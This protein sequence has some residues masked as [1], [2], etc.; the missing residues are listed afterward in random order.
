MRKLS[1]NSNLNSNVKVDVGGDI[2]EL[3]GESIKWRDVFLLLKAEVDKG[4]L[5]AESVRARSH[6]IIGAFGVLNSSFSA[7]N[8][9][10]TLFFDNS[11]ILLK[12]PFS[13]RPL[14]RAK[15]FLK[16]RNVSFTGLRTD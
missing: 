12:A 16:L 7:C 14:L 15:R 5:E 10:G 6:I 13:L 4:F 2:W 11:L 3:Q 9:S 8:P 1:L